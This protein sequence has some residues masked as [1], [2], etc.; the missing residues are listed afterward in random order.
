MYVTWPLVQ[1]TQKGKLILSHDYEPKSW[2]YDQQF[3][4]EFAAH[5]VI[6]EFCFCRIGY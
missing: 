1:I 4:E 2:K 5:F 6:L 3:L